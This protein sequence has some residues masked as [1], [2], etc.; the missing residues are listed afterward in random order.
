MIQSHIG[1]LQIN[2]EPQNIAFY[3]DL[4]VFMGWRLLYEE[5]GYL[6]MGSERGASLWFSTPL[7]PVSSD[8]DGVGMNH[9]AIHVAAQADVDAVVAYLGERGITPL[10]ETPRHRAEFSS[11]PERTYYQVM[12]TSPDRLLFEVVYIGPK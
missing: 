7:K 8:Y 10:F 12:F 5:P 3:K 9:L 11:S 2:V 4:L 6:G 1:H